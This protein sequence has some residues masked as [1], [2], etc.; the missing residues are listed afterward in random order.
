MTMQ[1]GFSLQLCYSLLFQKTINRTRP[2]PSIMAAGHRTHL[3]CFRLTFLPVNICAESSS[4]PKIMI[5]IAHKGNSFVSGKLP[6]F[7]PS[8]LFKSVG[9]LETDTIYTTARSISKNRW[10]NV[11]DV[12]SNLSVRTPL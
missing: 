12:Q 5:N 3:C 11:K 2:V 9:N 10:K 6:Q 4:R 1:Q 7:R 8:P